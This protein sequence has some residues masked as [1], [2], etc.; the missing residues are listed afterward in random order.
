MVI[1]GDNPRNTLLYSALF[2]PIGKKYSGL[3][4]VYY[5]TGFIVGCWA[6]GLMKSASVDSAVNSG[7]PK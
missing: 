7:Y 3:G 4:A 2:K 6:S 5:V 1:S